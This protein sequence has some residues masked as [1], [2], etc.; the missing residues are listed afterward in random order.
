MF[1]A[2]EHTQERFGKFARRLA[3]HE[4]MVNL[5]AVHANAIS[6]IV[7]CVPAASLDR[8]W[9]LYPNPYPKTRHR[10]QRWHA[11][12]FAAKLVETLKPGGELRLATNEQFYA[13]EAERDWQ[14]Q[15]LVLDSRKEIGSDEAPRTHFERKYIERGETCFDLTF[16]RPRA[17]DH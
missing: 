11:M 2:I 6:W 8:I 15:G 13:N 1:I 3:N 16:V 14:L 5:H 12:P 4:P 17:S 10:N 7:H 9:L